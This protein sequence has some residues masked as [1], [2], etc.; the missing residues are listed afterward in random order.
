LPTDRIYNRFKKRIRFILVTIQSARYKNASTRGI[1]GGQSCPGTGFVRVLPFPQQRY[2][3]VIILLLLLPERKQGEAWEPSKKQLSSGNRTILHEKVLSL[4]IL[5]FKVSIFLLHLVIEI[6]FG[7]YLRCDNKCMWQNS[8]R[9][10][11]CHLIRNV[12]RLVGN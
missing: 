10:T 5:G 3:P 12:I 9:G 8:P 7:T 2:K 6:K 11:I 1:C 4:F